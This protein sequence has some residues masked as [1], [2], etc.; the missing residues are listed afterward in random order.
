MRPGRVL[1]CDL[2]LPAAP[3]RW[4][5]LEL[6][7]LAELRQHQGEAPAGAHGDHTDGQVRRRPTAP[8]IASALDCGGQGHVNGPLE[9][10]AVSDT[11]PSHGNITQPSFVPAV[12]SLRVPAAPADRGCRPYPRP[13]HYLVRLPLDPPRSAARTDAETAPKA[14]CESTR[15]VITNSQCEPFNRPD[16]KIGDRTRIFT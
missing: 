4:A 13:E 1:L 14:H 2:C 3:A 6:L 8:N 5:G 7:V 11:E 16:R 12:H 15:R 9:D 10:R